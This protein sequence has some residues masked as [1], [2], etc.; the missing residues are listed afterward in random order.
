MKSLL[1]NEGRKMKLSEGQLNNKLRWGGG[2][3]KK[4]ILVRNFK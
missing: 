3:I 1:T 4:Q 2:T